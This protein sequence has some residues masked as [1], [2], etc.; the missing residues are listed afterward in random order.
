MITGKGTKIYYEYLSNLGDFTCG[1]DCVI[2]S[3]VWIGD[4]VVMGDRVK[5]EGLV[6]IPPGVE[7]G[8]DVFIG[9]GAIF[10]NDPTLNMESEFKPTRTIVK[11]G[12]RIG[13]NATILAGIAIGKNSLIGM[14]S[15][16]IRD[17]PDNAKVAGNP[18]KEI[19]VA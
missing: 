1:K 17:V 14:G 19:G 8:N 16:V 12:A 11:D 10:T 15:V 3:N 4:G 18:A 6:F 7:I 5:V 2:H 13:A 9:P